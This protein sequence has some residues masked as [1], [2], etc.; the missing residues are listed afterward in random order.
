M[1][2]IPESQTLAA[3]LRCALAGKK[4][5]NVV[6]NA[7]PH[8]FAFYTGD[9]AGYHALLAGHIIEGARPVGGQVEL[10]AGEMRLL[11]GDGI[12][13]RALAPGGKP[14]PKHQLLITFEDG[15]QL[16]CTVQMYGGMWVYR[17]GENDSF[18]YRVALEKPSPLSEAFTPA[19]FESLAGP[20]KKS[21][22]VKAFLATEQRIPGLGNG[23]LQDILFGARV[24]P[25]TKLSALTDGDLER[26]HASV[27]ST[28]T[29]MTAQ[30]GRDTERDLFGAYGGYPTKLCSRTFKRPCPVCGGT[31][32]R[33]A[34]L[35]GNVYFCPR[36]QPLAE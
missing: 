14:P 16:V 12:N 22:S 20:C 18:Y 34:F 10:F 29:Q 23:V 28:L 25:R 31:L 6:A 33:Q 27:V 36:C 30:G 3:Q 7:S 15:S 26:L 1:I 17:A 9:P 24:H 4:I 32:V 8:G 5:E 19:Y 21:L 35:G 13:V 11:L 2:E